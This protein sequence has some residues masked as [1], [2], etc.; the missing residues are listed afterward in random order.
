[1]NHPVDIEQAINQRKE[2]CIGI[3]V[4]GRRIYIQ[5]IKD[6]RKIKAQE[7]INLKTAI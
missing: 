3:N 7:E 6:V 5:R 4:N 1:M 2:Y